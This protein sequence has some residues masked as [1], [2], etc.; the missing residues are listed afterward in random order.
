MLAEEEHPL[1]Q[2]HVRNSVCP[3]LP[4][5]ALAYLRHPSH[6]AGSCCGNNS[7]TQCLRTAVYL[8]S[9]RVSTTIAQ[10]AWFCFITLLGL[11]RT[12]K[13]P[14]KILQV[15]AAGEK[16]PLKGPA[17]S[18]QCAGSVWSRDPSPHQSLVGSSHMIYDLGPA[19]SSGAPCVIPVS[20]RRSAETIW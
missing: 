18:I 7:K 11:G 20:G 5:P 12:E 10:G 8:D 6:W 3:H 1:L 2:L 17:S 9:Y 13:S 14:S 19:G 16:R 15:S 4:L